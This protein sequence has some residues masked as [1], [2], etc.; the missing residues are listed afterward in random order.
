M[1]KDL[2]Q[3]APPQTP[4][5]SIWNQADINIID[6]RS[7][8]EFREGT[9]PG[10]VNIPLLNDMERSLIGILYKQYGQ[11]KAVEKGYELFEPKVAEFLKQFEQ[12]PRGKKAAVFCARGGMRSQV[13]VS[14]LNAHGFEGFQVTGGYKAFRN[15]NLEK[16]DR[17]IIQHPVILHGKTGV[18]KTL[19]LNRLDNALDL[20]GLADHRG[21]M[22]GG[23]G[24][25]PV[26]QKTFDAALLIRLESLDNT[27]PVFIEGESRKIG[28]INLPPALFKQMKSARNILLESSIETRACRTVEEYIDRQPEAVDEIRIIIQKLSKDLGKRGVDALLVDFDRKNY[29]KCFEKILLNYY[30][31]KYGFS[32]K[33]LAF[34]FTVSSEDVVSAAREITDYFLSENQDFHPDHN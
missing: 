24:K 14:F 34:E 6:V 15:W 2:H 29:D 19:V 12:L 23:V 17:F 26:T 3:Q 8:S 33:D 11:Q 4:I 18:G 27:R 25:K 28:R 7:P 31:R 16:L 13:I 9:I 10:S 22:F 32:M 1:K 20:E 30:D 21:S 5:K